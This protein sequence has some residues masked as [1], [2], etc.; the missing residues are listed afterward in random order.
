MRKF[1]V[2]LTGLLLLP[3]CLMSQTS[4]CSLMGDVNGSGEI[5]ILDALIIA[6][7]YVG[8]NPSNYNAA[9]AD[10]DCSDSVDIVDALLIAQFY[11]GSISSF[12]CGSTPGNGNDPCPSEGCG[13]ELSDLTS[14]IYTITSAGLS[15]TYTI[16]IPANYDKN[17]PYRL[18]FGMH[19]MG[20]DMNTIVN[21]NYYELKTYAQNANV[22]CIFVAPEGNSDTTP[23][24]V[25]DNKDHIFFEDML[26]LF[27]E[28]L[29]VDT[30]RV[31]CCGFSYGAMITYSLSLD[32][33]KDLRAVACYAPANWNIWL[34]AN[35]HESVAYYQ[36]TGTDDNLCSW[37]YSD[38]NKQGG[39]YC[40]L[41]HIEDNGCAVPSTIPTA[42][43]STHITTEF[44]G[45]TAGYP[46]VF[47]SF[48]GGHA[49]NVTDPGS[50]V[51][52]IAQE[53]WD[54]F[55]RF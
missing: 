24:R 21:N 36:T 15:R 55:M 28:K 40:L 4:S 48:Q 12:P 44:S 5:D 35:T 45:C 8:L 18:I 47:G 2:I 7:T 25:N 6:Q 3:V 31:F 30:S 1:Y 33:Q 22:Q 39:K 27:K 19:M 51:N 11:V 17:K 16:E 29:C 14:G 50:N 41:T 49:M 46:V 23:W 13:K 43:S 38:A 34:P 53:T 32:F 10:V 54:F 42:T 52:W 9:C 37:V 20:G 26:H